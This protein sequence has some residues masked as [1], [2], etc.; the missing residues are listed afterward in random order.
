MFAGSY[1]VLRPLRG[2][3]MG[4]VHVVERITTGAQRALKILRQEL[5]G[6][7]RL[8]RLFQREARIGHRIS[9]DHVVDF[10]DAGVAEGTRW[11]VMD[12]LQG[13]TLAEH[14]RGAGPFFHTLAADILAQVAHALAAAHAEGVVHRDV[15]P[16]AFSSPHRSNRAS[17]CSSSCS[18]SV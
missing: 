17:L 13:E 6:D 11:L 5:C 2:G 3:G 8:V 7:E 15:K 9:S 12:L 4:A 16:R 1:R 18:I 10:I 14:V